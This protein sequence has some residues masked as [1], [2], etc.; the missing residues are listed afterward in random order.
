[1]H[2]RRGE[3]GPIAAARMAMSKGELHRAI[4]LIKQLV[5]ATGSKDLSVRL[6]HL[7]DDFIQAE[8]RALVHGVRP[9]SVLKVA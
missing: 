4:R 5:V 3:S 7:I 1:M 9:E 2:S 6:R 8:N